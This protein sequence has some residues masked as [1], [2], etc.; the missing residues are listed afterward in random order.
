MRAGLVE[1]CAKAGMHLVEIVVDHGPP[2][3]RASEYP[4]LARVARGEADALLV[5]RSAL[6]T[7]GRAA[8]RLKRLCPEGSPGWLTAEALR[9][10]G[11][12]PRRARVHWTER[13]RR[14]AKQ[15]ADELRAAGLSLRQ[16]VQ[17][18]ESEGYRRRGGL[19][20]NEETAGAVLGISTA[21]DG[22]CEQRRWSLEGPAAWSQCVAETGQA[23]GPAPDLARLGTVCERWWSCT[24]VRAV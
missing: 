17:V 6:F 13:P 10:A 11:M 22:R 2:K 23:D 19:S 18:L 12:L 8:D 24:D 9:E 21:E 14:P 15:R 16:V 1:L 20:W 3:R 4:A 7:R 5:M